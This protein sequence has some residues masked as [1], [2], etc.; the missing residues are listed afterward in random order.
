M[1]DLMADRLVSTAKRSSLVSRHFDVGFIHPILVARGIHGS[2]LH[3]NP[4]LCERRNPINDFDGDRLE[5]LLKNPVT[6]ANLR[7]GPIR[8]VADYIGK[9]LLDIWLFWVSCG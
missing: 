2:S 6:N 5:S 4:R 9:S 8:D 7:E 1:P 3:R